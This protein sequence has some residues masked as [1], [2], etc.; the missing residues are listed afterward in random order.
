MKVSFKITFILFLGLNTFYWAYSQSNQKIMETENIIKTLKTMFESTDERNWTKVQKTMAE[1]V[2]LD[3][4]SL[5]GSPATTSPS[6]QIIQS[7]ESSL[8]GFDKTHHHISNF[9]VTENKNVADVH[10]TVKADHFIGKEVWTVEGTYDTEL[11]K[12]NGN[13]VIT[14]H[15]LNLAK[16]IGNKSLPVQATEIVR[17][18]TIRN[19][20]FKNEG[21]VLKGNLHLPAGFSE[22]KK[23]KGIVVAGS[24]TTVKEQM[25]DLYAA[26][27]AKERFVAL[28][29]D[30]RNYGESEGQPRNFEVAEMKAQDIINATNYLKTLIFSVHKKVKK[31]I[32]TA[33]QSI[34]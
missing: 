10:Y 34:F 25:P 7:W 4:T 20:Q 6:K 5:S 13:W 12:T 28:T 2:L 29:F 14:K 27:L 11:L 16:Q 15:K 26:K 19:V 17:A 8:L 1:N 9:K 31:L 3:F 21:L 22:N 32:F 23:Y 33:L 24:W 18:K 30:F